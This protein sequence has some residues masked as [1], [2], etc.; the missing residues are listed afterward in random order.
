MKRHQILRLDLELTWKMALLASYLQWGG[1][2]TLFFK[3]GLKKVF[4]LYIYIVVEVTMNMAEYGSRRSQQP[5]N[6]NFE[7]IIRGLKSDIFD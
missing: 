6:V 3:A 4:F 7:P 1:L 5:A 2:K